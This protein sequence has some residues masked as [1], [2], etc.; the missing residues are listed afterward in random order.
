MIYFSLVR[1][2]LS[3]EVHFIAYFEYKIALA[4]NC[5]GMMA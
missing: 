5:P 4:T 3:S 2:N 1:S